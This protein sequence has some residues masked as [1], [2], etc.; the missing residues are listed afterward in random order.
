[1]N[2]TTRR[3][4]IARQYVTSGLSLGV[5]RALSPLQSSSLRCMR[6]FL[7]SSSPRSFCS[8]PA[9]LAVS[10]DRTGRQLFLALR[11]RRRYAAY[12]STRSAFAARASFRASHPACTGTSVTRIVWRTGVHAPNRFPRERG[13]IPRF[14]PL[15]PSPPAPGS[16][17]TP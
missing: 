9:R 5:A 17:G 8:S 16:D 6:V 7:S 11:R 2:H 12:G 14:S 3:A 1:M 10:R 15:S 13:K 4:P